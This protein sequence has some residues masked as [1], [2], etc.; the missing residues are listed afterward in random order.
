[1]VSY[2]VTDMSTQSQNASKATAT[3]KGVLIKKGIKLKQRN[4]YDRLT[5][6]FHYP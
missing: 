1:M 4:K 3:S 6:A 2:A 5:S